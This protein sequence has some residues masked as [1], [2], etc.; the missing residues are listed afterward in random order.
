MGVADDQPRLLRG[1]FIV[2]EGGDGSGKSTQA[3]LLAAHLD[4]HLTREP[5]G[6]PVGGAGMGT[7]TPPAGVCATTE[8]KEGSCKAMAEGIYAIKVTIDV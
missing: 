5:G 1:K 4:A 6:T 7:E 3:A 8:V 2:F